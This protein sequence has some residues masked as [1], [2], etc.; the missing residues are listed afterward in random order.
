MSELNQ[1]TQTETPAE[2]PAEQ[3]SLQINDILSAAQII[4]LASTRGAFRTEEFTQIG[5]VYDRMV[6]FLQAS[7]ALVPTP[8][9]GDTP[10][11]QS[12]AA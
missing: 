2:T 6:S 8:A 5:A 9:P 7:G 11:E 3:V 1:A 12:P 10:A 4:Q